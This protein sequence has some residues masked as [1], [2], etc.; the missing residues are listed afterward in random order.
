MLSSSE[1]RFHAPSR[2]ASI[3]WYATSRSLAVVMPRP[4][5]TFSCGSYSPISGTVIA[6][7]PAIWSRIFCS[8]RW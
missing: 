8:Q 6:A 5:S 3:D 1:C 7:R 4:A 2:E